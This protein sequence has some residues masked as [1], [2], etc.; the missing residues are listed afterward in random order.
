M[1]NAT[2]VQ[3]RVLK[4]LQN[5]AA[6]AQKM[7]NVQR[8]SGIEPAQD[9]TQSFHA[10]AIL[11]T[12]LA[13]AALAGGVPAEWIDQARERG[14]KAI[15]WNTNLF[16]RRAAPVDRGALVDNLRADIDRLAR[17]TG[18]H[19]AYTHGTGRHDD[20][21][22][23]VD[24]TLTTLWRRSAQIGV[25]LGIDTE[26]ARQHWPHPQWI[27]QASASAAGQT[28]A[29]LTQ[30]WH[31]IAN[32]D[33]TSYTAQSIA[34]AAAGITPNPTIAAPDP[35]AM[36]DTLS[37]RDVGVSGLFSDA[38]GA[39]IGAAVEATRSQSAHTDYDADITAPM[40]S[41]PEINYPGIDP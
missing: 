39:H 19:A 18:I 6:D 22:A 32:T 27:E 30:N 25:L 11:H 23:S 28:Q 2:T 9:R 38:P 36:L 20:T 12:E 8:A 15:R 14:T 21:T 7:L 41:A 3:K 33:M 31:A 40:F 29:Q 26:Q 17:F 4:A 13:A 34:L 16:L 37:G 5:Q 10:R 24:Q 1:A 35:L